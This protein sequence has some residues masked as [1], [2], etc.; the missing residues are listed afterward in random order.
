MAGAP[1]AHPTA[2]SDYIE[3]LIKHLREERD[4]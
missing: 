1:P 2:E 4:G 3:K